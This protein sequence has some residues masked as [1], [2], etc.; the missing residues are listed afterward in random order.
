MLN[1]INLGQDFKYSDEEVIN[2]SLQVLTKNQDIIDVQSVNENFENANGLKGIKTKGSFVYKTTN[3]KFE[4]ESV[5]THQSKT[6]FNQVWIFSKADDKYADEIS[7]R[8]FD[9][10]LYKTDN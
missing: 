8:L 10:M 6:N 3:T 5:L 4:F 7:E 1:T 2:Y 9:S